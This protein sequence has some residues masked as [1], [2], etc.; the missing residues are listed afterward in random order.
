MQ[1]EELDSLKRCVGWELESASEDPVSGEA[2]LRLGG[3][4][5]LRLSISRAGATAAVEV[6]PGGP[7]WEV[8][9]YL[10]FWRSRPA[11]SP[12]YCH[13]FSCPDLVSGALLLPAPPAEEECKVPAGQRALLAALAGCAD[14]AAEL[15]VAEAKGPTVAALVQ[16]TTARLRWAR[17]EGNCRAHA[18][19]GSRSHAAAGLAAGGWPGQLHA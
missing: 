11:I 3:L 17:Q 19:D 6:L 7:A 12:L 1:L 8:L 18:Y 14:G 15:P 4:F 16:A 10:K 5:R 2:A 9:G 13:P